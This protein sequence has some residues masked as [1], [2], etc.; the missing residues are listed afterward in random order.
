MLSYLVS[1][2]VGWQA[3]ITVTSGNAESRLSFGQKADATDLI[4]GLYDVPAMLSGSIQ[5]YFQTEV[6][7]FWRDMWALGP[8]KKWWQFII[9][10]HTGE[11]IDITWNPDN[12]LTDA[13]VKLIDTANGKEID[14]KNSNFYPLEST[15][16]ALLLLEVT[17]K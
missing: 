5:V 12:L 10:S 16:K 7:T 17:S 9:T 4:D 6:D 8:G 15:N 11:P 14:M 2:F 13:N 3:S 1:A